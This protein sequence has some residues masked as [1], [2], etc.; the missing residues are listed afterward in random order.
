MGL[1]FIR[2]KFCITITLLFFA[3][4]V[5]AVSDHGVVLMYHHVSNET[6]AVT[7]ISPEKFE[8]HM[9]YL[10]E[11]HQVLP[12]EVLVEKLRAKQSLP[13]KAV[14]ITF[15]DGYDNIYANAHPILK[16]YNFPY[17][18]FINPPLIG[19]LKSQLD[20]TQV[21]SMAKQGVRFANHSSHHNHM[22]QRLPNK[23]EKAWLKRTMKDINDAQQVLS[24]KLG[25]KKRYLAYPYGEYNLALRQAIKAQGYTGFGQH[26][27]AIG[28]F[29][30]YSALPRFPAAGIYANLNSLETK[31]NSLALPVTAV[32]FTDPELTENNLKPVQ[33]LTLNVQGFSLNK[34]N[35]FFKGEPLPLQRKDNSITFAIT[36]ELKPGRARVNCT[37][38]SK[39]DPSRFYWYS[40]PYFI[41]TP[42]GKWLD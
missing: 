31:L 7:S 11:H 27:G 17:T 8:K 16:K 30:D 15:D 33:T 42:E 22:L 26:S 41:A 19:K 3:N 36:N 20:W 38:P 10:E 2:F 23:N 9:A 32:S 37:A 12:L 39:H 25:V 34:V 21:Q 29:S 35:C 14:A 18:V 1:G 24:S 40:Q 28:Q 6:P 5:G 13:D 4:T